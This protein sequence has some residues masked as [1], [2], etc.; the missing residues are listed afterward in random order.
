MSGLEGLLAEKPDVVV[1]AASHEAVHQ[2]AEILLERGIATIVLSGG[3]LCDD[4]LRARIE[5]AA[6]KRARC[7]TFPPAAS[8]GWT[9]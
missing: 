9:R 1:E 4:A 6:E 8:A 7:S 3:A 2:Y 5:R